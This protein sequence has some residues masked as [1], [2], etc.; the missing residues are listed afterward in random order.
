VGEESLRL[1]SILRRLLTKRFLRHSACAFGALIGVLGATVALLPGFRLTVRTSVVVFGLS[2]VGACVYSWRKCRSRQF[3]PNGLIFPEPSPG[4]VLTIDRCQDA[5]MVV[6][7]NRL[8]AHVYPN[9][10]PLPIERY[11]QWLLINPNIFVCLKDIRGHFQGY[12]DIYALSD[13]FFD[14]FEQGLVGEQEIRHTHILAPDKAYSCRRLY[15]A[16]MAVA[17]CETMAGKRNACCLIWGLLRYLQ[18][19]HQSSGERL[20]YASAVTREGERLLQRFQFTLKLPAEARCDP[21]PLYVRSV[22][23]ASIESI[24]RVLPDWTTVCQIEWLS[25]EG[26]KRRSK[27]QSR[28]PPHASEK[29]A[30]VRPGRAKARSSRQELTEDSG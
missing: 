12:F 30:P 3:S 1:Y 7:A 24:L 5:S 25:L 26:G 18:C 9:V 13:S 15:L 4:P 8:A 11:K 10:E 17:N 27:S 6:L 21:H 20:L 19:F 16:G 22:S 23:S 28:K 2:I 29:S 14:C